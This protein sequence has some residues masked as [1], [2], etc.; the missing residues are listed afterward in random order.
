VILRRMQPRAS[1]I[2]LL[3]MLCAACRSSAGQTTAEP[4]ERQSVTEPN[5][6]VDG[7][8]AVTEDVMEQRLREVAEQYADAFIERIALS[9][10]A[11]PSDAAEAERL[12]G[13]TVV[14]VTATSQ[15][16]EELP[17]ARVYLACG[18]DGDDD[19]TLDLP[20]VAARKG[21]IE[22]SWGRVVGPFRYDGI[23]VIPVQALTLPVCRLVIDYAKNRQG[24]VVTVFD[25]GVPADVVV[26]PPS[27][28]PS[29]EA[30]QEIIEREYPITHE[31]R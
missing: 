28:P 15:E 20:L 12:G 4:G 14:L 26:L 1:S 3:L 11:F 29:P 8:A 10:V 17:P 18:D 31:R 9:D 21:L 16:P 19:D 6:N 27:H 30:L 13:Y 24:Q 2:A 5:R 22:A 25:A 7:P 23:Y